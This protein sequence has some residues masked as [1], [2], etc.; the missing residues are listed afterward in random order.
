MNATVNVV[1]YKSKT[2]SNG[3][4]PIVL[5]ISKNGKRKYVSIGVSVS[6]KHWDFAKN[7]PKANCPNRDYIKKIILDKE[8]EY[9]KQILE[10]MSLC[11]FNSCAIL[12]ESW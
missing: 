3:E 5:R 6:P 10:F 4:H 2:L 8:A 1:C 7:T 9:Q 11:I 12:I